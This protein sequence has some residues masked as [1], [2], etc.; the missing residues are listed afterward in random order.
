MT[1]KRD[2]IAERAAID[3][4]LANL[5][6]SDWVGLSINP[7]PDQEETLYI[8]IVDKDTLGIKEY[9]EAIE[10][11]IPVEADLLVA[12]EDNT[13]NPDY[14]PATAFFFRW[15]EPKGVAYFVA[16]GYDDRSSGFWS[17]NIKNFSTVDAIKLYEYAES[18]EVKGKM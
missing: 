9:I 3:L 11:D 1:K 4:Y 17:K 10:T 7:S 2:E 6:R 5:D 8:K 15:I 13:K 16:T 12:V 18:A 14:L